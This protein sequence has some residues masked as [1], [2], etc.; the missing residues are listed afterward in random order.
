MCGFKPIS[1]ILILLSF[2]SFSVAR[3]QTPAE[4]VCQAME[5]FSLQ[6]YE[7]ALSLSTQ[8]YALHPS[9]DSLFYEMKKWEYLSYN[10]LKRNDIAQQILKSM[11]NGG[12]ESAYRDFGNV[13]HHYRN[14]LNIS[15]PQEDIV[16]Y[17]R[18]VR[19]ILQRKNH[20]FYYK[21]Y[22]YY[23]RLLQYKYG[24]LRYDLKLDAFS[25]EDLVVKDYHKQ[26]L[27]AYY[28]YAKG[29]IILYGE[30]DG[31]GSKPSW[32]ACTDPIQINKACGFLR[33]AEKLFREDEYN[34]ESITK[35]HNLALD[36]LCDAYRDN[37]NYEAAA[38]YYK[39]KLD[40]LYKNWQKLSRKS[41]WDSG[42]YF[43]YPHPFTAYEEY[44]ELLF[45]SN[46]YTEII[47]YTNNI[48]KDPLFEEYKDYSDYLNYHILR[49]KN[50]LGIHKRP[51]LI[52]RNRYCKFYEYSHVEN[53]FSFAE[54]MGDQISIDDVIEQYLHGEFVVN[55]ETLYILPYLEFY[56]YLIE[57]EDYQK[58]IDITDSV[59]A[60]IYADEGNLTDPYEYY[61]EETRPYEVTEYDKRI[62]TE[63]DFWHHANG[64]SFIW[65][66]YKYRAI[67]YSRLGDYDKAIANQLICVDN[68]RT[69]W[70][71]EPNE[72]ESIFSSTWNTVNNY[73]IYPDVE[74]EELF[75]LAEY[76]R[77]S[78]DNE[79]AANYYRKVISLNREIISK[80]LYATSWDE[81]V[82]QWNVYNEIYRSIVRN[83]NIVKNP[84]FSDI[85]FECSS[86][87]KSFLLNI[88][89]NEHAAIDDSNSK[90]TQELWK[91][92]LMLDIK[93]E[94]EH[95]SDD[96]R[97]SFLDAIELGAELE[98]IIPNTL[99]SEHIYLEVSNQLKNNEVLVDFFIT[100]DGKFEYLK[101]YSDEW[102]SAVYQDI[103]A[104]I[105]RK[106]WEKPKVVSLDNISEYLTT[107]L[108]PEQ[109]ISA[110]HSI[111]FGKAIWSQI[112]EDSEVVPGD[113]IYFIPTGLLHQISLEN[114]LIDDEQYISDIYEL[115]RL[116]SY[117]QILYPSEKI[118]IDDRWALFANGGYLYSE[119]VGTKCNTEYMG[120]AQLKINELDELPGTR[121]TLN[122]IRKN[123]NEQCLCKLYK[124][125]NEAEFAKLNMTSPE[126]IYI[127]S[128]GYYMKGNLNPKDSLY[129]FGQNRTVMLSNE[130]T[131]M[132]KTGIVMDYSPKYS[133]TMSDGLLTSKEISLL[134]LSTTKLACVSACSTGLGSTTYE[135]VYGLQRG[136]K[137]AGVQSLLV[138]LW[139]VDDKATEI[140]MKS[141]YD[142]IRKGYNKLTSLK[143][144]QIQVREYVEDDNG[145]INLGEPHPYADPYYW[146]G[147]VL[148][149]GNEK[150]SNQ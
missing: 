122:Y 81:K 48:L 62:A 14:Y 124:D 11:I 106:G 5:E 23:F 51:E 90:D 86:M 9:A 93:A 127:G 3:A 44:V 68:V 15:E 116:T 35:Y 135:G 120:L 112:I 45:D 66:S 148:I 117:R 104:C 143:N 60:I 50:K 138:S 121:R 125:F 92:K 107:L 145:E 98:S 82:R 72:R 133:T 57:R 80:F 134:D 34:D 20:S 132:Y 83:D 108:L 70:K 59:L 10:R 87:L 43:W 97:S 150:Y 114:L 41:P 73:S 137:L 24:D 128:H 111:E 6:N 95:F 61:K 100:S 74:K 84:Y 26:Y 94:R 139:D 88:K 12:V 27:D 99:P 63:R 58:L 142:N 49:A 40:Y 29:C 2:I 4:L 85:V 21:D 119:R 77:L 105:I 30:W 140:L 65:L 131:S 32:K 13:A 118:E 110:C 52:Y 71:F 64:G 89:L 53:S 54:L 76:Y 78:G 96:V 75:I 16:T 55:K 42:E 19:G 144:A 115:Y 31:T 101:P 25:K 37:A 28:N 103:S 113:V 7:S 79:N 8:F 47:N 67:A 36:N 146:A 33:I 136:F 91:K 149:D 123:E 147:F 18:A 56:R 39:I 69:D 102:K 109:S 129:L 38:F 126:L 17:E 130:E 1:K 22:P 141:F 46:Q